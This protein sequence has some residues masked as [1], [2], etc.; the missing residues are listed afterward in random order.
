[1][2]DCSTCA[3]AFPIC[4][5]PSVL[6]IG[7]VADDV[8]EIGVKFTDRATGRTM[9][10]VP[11]TDALPTVE[12]SLASPFAPG[13]AVRVEIFSTAGEDAGASVEFLPFV[14]AIGTIGIA[15]AA[16]TCVVFTAVKQFN[17]E[18]AVDTKE[19]E[20]LIIP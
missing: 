20:T 11:N 5:C 6:R 12:V 7:T 18:G 19:T 3:R 16:V 2:I 4:T 1:M 17:V 10:T 14:G 15:A 9:N 8:T 13:H